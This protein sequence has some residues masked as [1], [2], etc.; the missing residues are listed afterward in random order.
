MNLYLV[1]HGKPVADYESGDPP[2]SP[3]GE[4]EVALV[5]S[6]LSEMDVNVE[7]IYH[8]GKLR[9]QQTAGIIQESVAPDVE[10]SFKEGL[11]PND[12]IVGIVDD[13]NAADKNT[14]LVGH[15]PF[16]DKMAAFLLD[17]SHDSSGLAFRTATVVCFER[18]EKD[19]W[20]L[21]WTVSPDDAV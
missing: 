15:L 19:K 17:R 13:M 8:S 14:M 3:E 1:R 5:A 16:M 9:A 11:K 7:E 10:I 20:T 12:P 2:L 6:K 18:I 21:L 4:S